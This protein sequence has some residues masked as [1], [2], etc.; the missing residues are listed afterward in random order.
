MCLDFTLGRGKCLQISINFLKKCFL[1][2][3][4]QVKV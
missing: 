4:V 3:E 2:G 1:T